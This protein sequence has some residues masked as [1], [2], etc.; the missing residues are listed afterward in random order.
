MCMYIYIYIYVY[1][2]IYMHIYIYIYTL[3]G[4]WIIA[5]HEY[6]AGNTAALT[7]LQHMSAHSA[8]HN[9]TVVQT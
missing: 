6:T 9:F 5:R 1:V 7:W 2:C 8:G 3:G 4:W